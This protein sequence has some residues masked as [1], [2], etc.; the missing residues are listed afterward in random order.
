MPDDYANAPYLWEAVYKL[1]VAEQNPASR[2]KLLIEAQSAMLQR[3]QALEAEGGSDSECTALE[4]AAES[5]REMKVNTQSDG[6]GKSAA[7][8]KFGQP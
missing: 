2:Q 1:A 5:L 3:A 8:G 6:S 4:A 7:L